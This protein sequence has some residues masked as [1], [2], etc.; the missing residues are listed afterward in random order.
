[1]RKVAMFR[2]S[3]SQNIQTPEESRD[4]KKGEK[5]KKKEEEK[6]R[7]KKTRGPL[8]CALQCSGFWNPIRPRAIAPLFSLDAAAWPLGQ[9]ALGKTPLL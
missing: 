3:G 9:R 2:T 8:F 1:M 7:R 6:L 5:K 4:K